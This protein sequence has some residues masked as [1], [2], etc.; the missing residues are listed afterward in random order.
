MVPP[1]PFPGSCSPPPSDFADFSDFADLF[2]DFFDFA[3]LFAVCFA[4]TEGRTLLPP[5]ISPM[6]AI[7]SVAV[8]Q[9]RRERTTRWNFISKTGISRPRYNSSPG[10]A[11]K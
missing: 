8:K 3:D 7:V 9:A 4:T 1:L 6:K 10:K 2:D 11:R 5:P